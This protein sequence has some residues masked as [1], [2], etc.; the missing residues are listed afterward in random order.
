MSFLFGKLLPNNGGYASG[1]SRTGYFEAHDF[2]GGGL[3]PSKYPI[4]G[5]RARNAVGIIVRSSS[6]IPCVGRHDSSLIRNTAML[7]YRLL[8]IVALM[9]LVACGGSSGP[10]IAEANAKQAEAIALA[11]AT[12]CATASQCG[13]LTFAPPV[14]GCGCPSAYLAYSLVAPSAQAASAAAAQQNALAH[15]AQSYETPIGLCGC[16]APRAPVC[17]ATAGC[18]LVPY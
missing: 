13:V 8:S 10:P 12:P 15:L 3:R 17:D 9:S 11:S 4:Y 7:L 1:I 14:G 2:A 16:A 18:Q 5:R 6:A